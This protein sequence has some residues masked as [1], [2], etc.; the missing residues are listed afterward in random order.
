MET[1]TTD[2]VVLPATGAD[3]LADRLAAAL[4]AE[5]GA[6]EVRRFPDDE[7]YV[8]VDTPLAGREVIVAAALR[9]PDPALV[10]L[11]LLATTARDLGARRVGVVAPYLPYMR[12]D[13]RFRPGEG[14]T[15][16]YVARWLS[17]LIDWLVTVDP[18]LHRHRHLADVYEI[19][20]TALS[21]APAIAAWLRAHVP[22]PVLVGPDAESAVATLA[23][24]PCIVL[25]KRRHGDRAVDVSV[26][27]VERWRTHTPVL[28]DDIISTARTMSETVGHLR[29]AGMPAAICIGVHA[30]FA[31]DAEGALARAGAAAVVTCDTIAHATNAIPTLDLLVDG[32]RRH[33]RRPP[34]PA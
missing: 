34:A 17:G 33:L 14:V 23:G 32:V 31:D 10:P 26:P 16:R 12:Q 30:V 19:P 3:V 25:D 7:T 13:A 2:T 21:A 29:R 9:S 18:H 20:A 1:E 28:V 8:R 4:G 22:A 6:L 27:D 15:S 5:R 24:A 11:A